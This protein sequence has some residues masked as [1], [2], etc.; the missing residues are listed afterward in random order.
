MCGH[1]HDLENLKYE[2]ILTSDKKNAYAYLSLSFIREPTLT[3]MCWYLD[4]WHLKTEKAVSNFGLN[5]FKNSCGHDCK[6]SFRLP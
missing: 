3:F 6:G 5:F 2:H 1:I 4:I